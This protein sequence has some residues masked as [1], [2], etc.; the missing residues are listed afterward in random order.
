MFFLKYLKKIPQYQYSKFSFES[1]QLSD[2][3]LTLDLHV[4]EY[5]LAQVTQLAESFR[6]SNIELF[7]PATFRVGA[8]VDS[9]VTSPVLERVGGNL[10]IIEGSTRFYYALKNNIQSI[11][12]IVIS[13][14]SK[15]LPA[16][17]R[18][19]SMLNL[20]SDTI[21]RSGLFE[22]LDKNQIREIESVVHPVDG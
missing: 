14:V 2:H 17:T 21:D 19:I 13:G 12:A 10:V 16:K 8:E 18:P 15:P 20:A 7:S 1:V 9:I 5:K 22:D 11:K 4:K 6:R 3:L